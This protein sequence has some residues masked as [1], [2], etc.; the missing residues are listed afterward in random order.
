MLKKTV[1]LVAVLLLT[2]TLIASFAS[3]KQSDIPDGYQLVA[4]EGDK[5][6]L[7]VPTQGWMPNTTGG[8][9]SAFFSRVENTSV[10]VYVADD[11]GEMTVE[12]Y[13]EYCNEKYSAELDSYVFSGKYEKCVLGGQAARKYVFSANNYFLDADNTWEKKPYKFMQ[14]MARY[15]GDM[16]IFVYSSP[17]EYYD[18]HIEEVEG[19]SDGVGIIPYFVFADAYVSEDGKKYSDKVDVPEGM[20]LI[21]TDERAYRFFVPDEWKVNNRADISAAY[22]SDIDKS[23]V[24]VQLYICGIGDSVQSVETYFERCMNSYD[25]LFPQHELLK[26]DDIKM[27]DIDAKR[28]V[29]SVTSG[30]VE[31]KILQAIVKKGDA[32]YCLTYTATSDNY[33]DHISDVEKMIDAFEIR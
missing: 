17:E 26:E 23:N 31:Y 10:S 7:Y 29:L 24:S 4:C 33:D 19:N 21:S 20:K 27:S 30:G 2:V 12:E 14:V 22:Y 11:A 28:Y 18:S 9:T 32:I 8:V 1:R 6:R 25:T 5:F 15:D 3:C 13:W 16:Y